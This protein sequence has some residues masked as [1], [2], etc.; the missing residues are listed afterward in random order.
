VPGDVMVEMVMSNGD[1]GESTLLEFFVLLFGIFQI[2]ERNG[3]IYGHVG[4][5]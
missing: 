1:D 5:S 3:E 4:G 2:M